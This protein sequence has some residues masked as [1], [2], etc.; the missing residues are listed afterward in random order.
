MLPIAAM[1]VALTF[2]VPLMKSDRH[3]G[4][5]PGSEAG[6]YTHAQEKP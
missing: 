4:L 5:S 2:T 6:G 3:A 1:W